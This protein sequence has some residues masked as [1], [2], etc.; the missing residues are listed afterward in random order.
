[1]LI[2]EVIKMLR[3]NQAPS[4]CAD[5]CFDNVFAKRHTVHKNDCACE[6]NILHE[7]YIVNMCG[8]DSI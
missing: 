3:A 8:D 5:A 4:R 6:N 1:M 7:S 2:E